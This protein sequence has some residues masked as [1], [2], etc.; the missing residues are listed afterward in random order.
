MRRFTG[1]GGNVMQAKKTQQ[2]GFDIVLV[3]GSSVAVVV[4]V[5]FKVQP[6]AIAKA[7]KKI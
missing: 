7:A 4:E 1:C 2:G 6:S 3:N 5:K